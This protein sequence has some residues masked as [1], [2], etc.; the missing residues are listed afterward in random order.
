MID[1]NNAFTVDWL[2]PTTHMLAGQEAGR[3]DM[4][5]RVDELESALAAS[6]KRVEELEAGLTEIE[7]DSVEEFAVKRAGQALREDRK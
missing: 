6:Q 4:Q 5:P 1:A 3:E 7:C 2:N